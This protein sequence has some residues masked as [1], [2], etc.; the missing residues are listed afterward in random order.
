LAEVGAVRHRY[1]RNMATATV[2]VYMQCEAPAVI[3]AQG[4]EHLDCYRNQN[5]LKS[6]LSAKIQLAVCNSVHVTN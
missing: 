4:T 6:L 2:Q 1:V 3:Q 5:F